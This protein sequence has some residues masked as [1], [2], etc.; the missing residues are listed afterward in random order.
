MWVGGGGVTPYQVR[1]EPSGSNN[2]SRNLRN[3][4][5]ATNRSDFIGYYRIAIFYLPF[6]DRFDKFIVFTEV[7][8]PF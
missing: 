3:T 8:K 1:P 5:Y 6:V 4:C 7:N 2:L